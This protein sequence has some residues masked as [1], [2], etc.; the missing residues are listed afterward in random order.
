MG[1]TLWL[2]ETR[3]RSDYK[4][5]ACGGEIVKGSAHFRHDPHPYAR[6]Q[7]GQKI[8]H[9]CRDCIL[10]SAPGQKDTITRRIRVLN[11]FTDEAEWRELPK[12]LELCPGVVVKIR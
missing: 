4:C 9:W 11:D 7:R 3:A 2:L 10:A 8:T 6:T 1:N 12:T 5:P